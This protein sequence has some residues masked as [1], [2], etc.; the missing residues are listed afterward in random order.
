MDMEQLTMNVNM[1]S[2][3]PNFYNCELHY[4]IASDEKTFRF[5]GWEEQPESNEL[6]FYYFLNSHELTIPAGDITMKQSY[7]LYTKPLYPL[8]STPEDFIATINLLDDKGASK[9]IRKF[10]DASIEPIC[11]VLRTKYG[12]VQ[13][14]FVKSTEWQHLLLVM[15]NIEISIAATMVY[16]KQKVHFTGQHYDHI[17][18]EQAEQHILDDVQKIG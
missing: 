14:H 2:L 18:E 3:Q 11:Q 16:F 6:R 12:N 15:D 17:K 7:Q 13:Q 9:A 1:H 5:A 4:I 8:L 10:N